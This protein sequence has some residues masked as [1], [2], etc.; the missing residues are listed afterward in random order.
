MCHFQLILAVVCLAFVVQATDYTWVVPGGGTGSFQNVSNWSPAPAS[1]PGVEDHTKFLSN[2][3]YAINFEGDATNRNA[4]V[5]ASGG[6]VAFNLNNYTWWLTNNFTFANT[7][8]ARFG[9]GTLEVGLASKTNVTLTVPANQKLILD[10]GTAR[11]RGA[12]TVSP[13]G[14]IEVNGGDHFLGSARDLSVNS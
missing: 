3:S 9:G 13:S 4:T 11:L 1:V 12:V 7:G 14:A 2:G 8:V 10:S 6:N 5:G